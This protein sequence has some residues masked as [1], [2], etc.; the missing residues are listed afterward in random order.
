MLVFFSFRG[1]HSHFLV[2]LHSPFSPP[3]CIQWSLS[4][5]ADRVQ[6]I[7]QRELTLEKPPSAERVKILIVSFLRYTAVSIF[8]FGYVSHK[9]VSQVTSK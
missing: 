1:I 7:S 6:S 9:Y 8:Q 5:Y 2:L 4:P 3:H